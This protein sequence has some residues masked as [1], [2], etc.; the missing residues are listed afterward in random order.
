M[1]P[2]IIKVRGDV[3]QDLEHLATLN[4]DT[5]QYPLQPRS[6]SGD[7]LPL[8]S[9]IEN[10]NGDIFKGQPILVKNRKSPYL[11]FNTVYPRDVIG[12][13]AC[14]RGPLAVCEAL[15]GRLYVLVP[16]QGLRFR[17]SS[18]NRSKRSWVCFRKTHVF[19]GG[20]SPCPSKSW[21]ESMFC[22]P[23]NELGH[24]WSWRIFFFFLHHCDE[25][26]GLFSA[27][28]ATLVDTA[29][30]RGPGKGTWW[31]TAPGSW[32]PDEPSLPAAGEGQLSA[33][34][35][36]DLDLIALLWGQQ[37]HWRN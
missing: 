18:T 28:G 19:L 11:L 25:T 3:T 4:P 1:F 20:K 9:V 16:W 30:L 33:Q 2:S 14:C 7:S 26:W 5:P 36:Q 17:V 34:S 27:V 15:I 37:S 35:V 29:C 13:L 23:L 10:V 32:D 6:V 12:G 22:L 24:G 21:K 8:F 31:N